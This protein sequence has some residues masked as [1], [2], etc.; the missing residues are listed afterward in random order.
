MSELG[1]IKRLSD[2][3]QMIKENIGRLLGANVSVAIVDSAAEIKYI[4]EEI[5]DFKDFI[6]SFAKGNFDLLSIGDHSLPLSGT[7]IAFFKVSEKALIILNS[8][9]GPV[10]QLL[11]FKGRMNKYS[12][13][14]DE[15]LEKG[16]EPEE[17]ALSKAAV[18]VP[19]LTVSIANKKFGMEEAK[20]L[21]LVNGEN[22]ISDICEK[23]GLPQL[24]VDEI[25][26]KYQKKKWIK[27]KRVIIGVVE[28]E[29]KGEKK[30]LKQKA[31]VT[32][33]VE[34]TAPVTP[35]IEPGAESVYIFPILEGEFK[36]KKFPKQDAQILY[37]C[38]GQYTIEDIINKT[39]QN[40]L[41]VMEVIKKYEKKKKLKLT[42]IVPSKKEKVQIPQPAPQVTEVSLETSQPSVAPQTQI[43]VSS[44]MS[45]ST[46]QPLENEQ[47]FDELLEIMETTS[48]I[49]QSALEQPRIPQPTYQTQTQPQSV[50][51]TMPAPTIPESP[52]SQVAPPPPQPISQDI[53]PLQP[54]QSEPMQSAP[55]KADSTK[56]P[57]IESPRIPQPPQNVDVSV[58][59]GEPVSD[60]LFD[61]LT[62]LLEETAP[63][64][65]TTQETPLP[66]EQS[67]IPPQSPAIP[68]PP[69]QTEQPTPAE[70]I[71]SPRSQ[72]SQIESNVQST[73]V[74]S[75]SLLESTEE[76]VKI[77][78]Y[79]E[80]DPLKNRLERL[81]TILEE[82]T[83]EGEEKSEV[84]IV[85]SK[86]ICPNCKTHVIMMAKV[87]PNCNRPLRTCP[88]CKSPIT[89][90]ARICPSC[91]S[92]L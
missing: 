9:K 58:V 51:S 32:R 30:E 17:K 8:S 10:G 47:V 40:K 15:L 2:L 87:C 25:L 34:P 76:G 31:P 5:T 42:K 48:P 52:S 44:P 68:S 77:T 54:T 60:A 84:K 80:E 36:G 49:S 45:A 70:E 39:G 38:D 71:I 86:A 19:V 21:H 22:T 64:S 90:F 7:N 50:S 27:L 83:D 73:V 66:S 46:P 61:D 65:P 43:P 4:D 18:R 67:G 81:S 23:T 20:V 12:A 24:K 91:G 29:K 35:S 79:P 16:P 92:L 37:Y 62:S 57:S 26:R 14:I 3:V 74:S 11:A 59:K 63:I 6:I 85:G 28:K 82:N 75:S 69:V 53:T 1:E 72:E 56:T 78:T 55:T 13:I 88:N 33:P 89:L 41:Q